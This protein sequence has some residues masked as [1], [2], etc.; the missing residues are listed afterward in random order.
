MTELIQIK[1]AGD[2][3]QENLLAFYRRVYNRPDYPLANERFFRWWLRDNPNNGNRR[4][5]AKIAMHGTAIVGHYA[6][7][8]VRLWAGGRVYRAFWAGNLVVDDAYRMRGIGGRLIAVLRQEGEVGLD[9]GADPIAEPMLVKNGWTH[10]GVLHRW[11]GIVDPVRALPLAVDAR[12][13]EE[14]VLPPLAAEE[15][16]RPDAIR[17]V[18]RFGADYDLFWQKR[19]LS[20]AYATDRDA[21]HMN[22]RYADHPVFRYQIFE[23][24]HGNAVEGY[25]IARKEDVRGVS[26]PIVAMRIVEFLTSPGFEDPL[27][28]YLIRMAQHW[29]AVLIDFFCASASFGTVFERYGFKRDKPMDKIARLFSPVALYQ[30]TISFNAVAISRLFATG[31]G[32]PEEWYVTSGDGDQDR[33]NSIV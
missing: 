21:E 15:D 24:R 33:P 20:I 30:W 12:A 18:E 13:L 17:A 29:D 4:I 25:A 9:V 31:V 14:C 2:E 3:H 5:S 10:M 1:D 26:E 22:W 7:A 23:I 16:D 32:S 28:R 6:Y 11:I 27:V 8:P 19:R